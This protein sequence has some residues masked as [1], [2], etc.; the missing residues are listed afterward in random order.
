LPRVFPKT[1]LAVKDL[2]PNW[3]PKGRTKSP[4]NQR[5]LIEVASDTL[6]RVIGDFV[7]EDLVDSFFDG[8]LVHGYATS[9]LHPEIFPSLP[10]DRL[11]ARII[12]SFPPFWECSGLRYVGGVWA[13]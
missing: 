10:A 11:I 9:R 6:K 1:D 12:S 4:I 8:V 5:A 7:G 13:R 3:K 2:G